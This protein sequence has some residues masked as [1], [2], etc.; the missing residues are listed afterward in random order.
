[1]LFY[2]KVSGSDSMTFEQNPQSMGSVCIFGGLV[3]PGRGKHEYNSPEVRLYLLC[4]KKSKETTKVGEE[5]EKEKKAR[6][7]GGPSYSLGVQ[8][9]NTLDFILSG[10]KSLW[11][12]LS[13]EMT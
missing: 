5:G 13:R 10:R 1:M 7:L 8:G 6:E 9:K 11:R 12:V 4:S 3:V 2:I